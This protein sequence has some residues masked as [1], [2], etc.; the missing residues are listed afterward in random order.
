[1]GHLDTAA[2]IAGLLKTVLAVSRGQI[3]PLLNFHT[4]NPALKLEE[5]PFTIPVSAQAWQDE[6][7]YAGVSSFGIGGTNCHM[8]V[9]SLPDALN[10]RKI[11]SLYFPAAGVLVSVGEG[12]GKRINMKR[13]I[14]PEKERETRRLNRL[15]RK[16][17]RLLLDDAAEA[18]ASAR[19]L[20]FE[21]EDIYVAAMDFEKAGRLRDAL[22][23]E[24]F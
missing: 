22:I 21:L 23:N 5:S 6:M 7:R 14:D 24:I 11:R 13:F 4:P 2:G 12:E 3:P 10:A 18:F 1:M 15:F 19:T 17:S 20:H 16:G 9:A 8:I